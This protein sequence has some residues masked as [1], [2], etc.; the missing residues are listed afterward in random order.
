MGSFSFL[1]KKIAVKA[2][3]IFPTTDRNPFKKSLGLF[4]FRALLS[5]SIQNE[6]EKEEL[7]K[8]ITIDEAHKDIKENNCWDHE[9][10]S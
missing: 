9:K 5:W 2:I 10:D 7:S 6:S 1:K 3:P 4:P 8:K